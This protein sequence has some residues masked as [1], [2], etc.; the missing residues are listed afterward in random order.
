MNCNNSLCQCGPT[1]SDLRAVFQ[2]H[3]KLWATYNKVMYETTHSQDLKPKQKSS[4]CF[5]EIIKQ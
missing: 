1:T 3:E 4:E 2:K 5:V